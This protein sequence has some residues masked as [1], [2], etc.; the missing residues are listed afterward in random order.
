VIPALIALAS[1]TGC[2][3]T[4]VSTKEEL[5]SLTEGEGVVF[6]SVLVT[7]EKE[8]E[9]DSIAGGL[10]SGLMAEKLDWSVFIWETGLNPFK[11]SY[12]VAPRPAKEEVF[13]RKLPAGTYRIDRI[14]HLFEASRPYEALE[15][16]V[17]AHFS[18]KP[19]QVT[20]IGKLMVNFPHR[21][22]AGS[23]VEIR[24]VD[25]QD[26]TTDKLRA[27]HPSIVG[28]SVK[29]LAIREQ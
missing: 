25:A 5:Q 16:S 10:F 26:E 4:M 18:V 19:R 2:V 1:L 28:K 21:V 17:A 8:P 23:P 6:G 3:A 15:F 27:V 7:V 13:I 24:I 12:R 29:E 20:Y 14:E 22:K 9:R 11:A